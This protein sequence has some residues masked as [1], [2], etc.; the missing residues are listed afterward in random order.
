MDW[1]DLQVILVP[2]KNALKTPTATAA[3]FATR[4]YRLQVTLSVN[5][6]KVT[7]NI[8]GKTHGV[9]ALELTLAQMN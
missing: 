7:I 9:I 3:S 6:Q 4:F 2:V 8:A 5:R 1:G